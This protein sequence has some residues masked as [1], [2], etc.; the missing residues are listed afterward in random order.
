MN[1]KLLRC[2]FVLTVCLI[3]FLSACAFGENT[4]NASLLAFELV[5]G[6]LYAGMKPLDRIGKVR[7]YEI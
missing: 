6:S 5:Y 7:M 1:Y 2:L 3:L 4:C